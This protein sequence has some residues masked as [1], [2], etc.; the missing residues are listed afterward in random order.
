MRNYISLFLY[1]NK[2]RIPKDPK[3]ITAT[4]EQPDG[5]WRTWKLSVGDAVGFGDI[6][7]DIQGDRAFLISRYDENDAS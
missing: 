6:R 1:R 5:Q 4:I 7:I 3:P 2:S